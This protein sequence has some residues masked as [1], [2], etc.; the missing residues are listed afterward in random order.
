MPRARAGSDARPEHDCAEDCGGDDSR[1]DDVRDS[2][3]PVEVE[4]REAGAEHDRVTD[5]EPERR[6]DVSDRLGNDQSNACDLAAPISLPRF[7]LHA[8]EI[9]WAD[10]ARNGAD[11]LRPRPPVEK[12]AL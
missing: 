2:I 7:V 1:G 5:A 11:N 9:E 12:C 3:A 10:V 8:T 6:D 4:G